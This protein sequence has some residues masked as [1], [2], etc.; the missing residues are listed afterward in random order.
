VSSELSPIQRIVKFCAENRGLVLFLTALVI[1]ASWYSAKTIHIDALPD[2]SDT[3]VVVYS[4]WDRSPDVLENQVTYPIVRSLLGAPK[5]KSIRAFTD[6]GY[7]FVY[8]IF[9]DEVDLYWARARVNE[10]MGKIT[11]SLPQGVKTEMGPDA[12][13]LGWVYQ[14][15]LVSRDGKTGPEKLRALNDFNLKYHLLSVPGV[16][17]IASMGG[18]QKQYQ[19]IVDPAK[20]QIAGLTLASVLD[21]VRG[22]NQQ[23]GGRL[24]EISGAEYMVRAHGYLQSIAD[25]EKISLGMDDTGNPIPLRAVASVNEASDLRRG[26]TDLDGRGDSVA[27]VVIMRQGENAYDVIERVKNKIKEI[28]RF[29]PEGVEVVPTY[30]RSELIKHSIT[31]LEEKLIEE[32]IIV[33]LVILLF[34]W[35]FPSAIIPILTIPIAVLASFI[36]LNL[37]GVSSNIMSLAGIA[38]SIGVLVDGAIV[39]V[40]NAYKKLEEWDSH[41]RVGDYHKVRLEALLEVGPSVFFS[42]L[43]VAVSFLPVFTLVDQEGRLFKPLAYSKN[44]AMAVAAV[45][46]ITV[47]PALRML[48]TRMEPFQFKSKFWSKTA[49]TLLVGKYLPEEKHPI[50]KRLIAWYGPVCHFTLRHP[51]AVIVGAVLMMAATVPLYF[52]LGGE[53]FPALYEETLLYMPT[54]A[55]GLSGAEAQK[56][57]TMTNKII[58]AQ[59]EVM[60]VFGKAGRAETSTDPAPLS[61]IET[62]IMLKPQAEW[63]QANRFYS[64]LPKFTWPLFSW[65]TPPHVTKDE[66]IEIYNRELKFPGLTNAFTMPIRNRVDM[67][68]TGMKTPLGLKIAGKTLGEIEEAAVKAERVVRDIPGVR[69][70]VA[71]RTASGYFLDVDIRRDRIA[72]YNLTIDDVQQFIR[73]AIGGEMLTETIEGRERYAVTIRYGK[74]WRDTPEKIRRIPVSLASGSSVPLGEIADVQTKTGAGMIRNENGFLTGYVYIDTQSS[75]L[76]GLSAKIDKAL[77]TL[78]PL[79]DGITIQLSGQYEN[80][81]RVRERLKIVIPITLFLILLLLYF[82]TRSYIKTLIVMLAVPFSL[83]GAIILLNLL[84]YH[85]SIAV[86]VGMIAL[87]GLDAET[88]VFMLMYLDLEFEKRKATLRSEQ[89]L[90]EVIY[91]GAVH[92]LRPKMMTVLAAFCGLL[93]VMFSRGTGSDIMKAI[94]APMVGGLFTS[95]LLE[96]IVY[97]PV[98]FLWKRRSINQNPIIEEVKKEGETDEEDKLTDGIGSGRADHGGRRKRPRR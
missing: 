88:G 44:L 16:A 67:L 85:I 27:G 58:A 41:G 71:E 25:I 96:L 11:G 14:Y 1:G 97:P 18:F 45:M 63:R 84:G 33:S 23:A 31:T 60:R 92:R 24:M 34:L 9:Q 51:R 87:M 66:L 78:K 93:P 17:E 55:P 19:V 13:G 91:L 98:Y 38:I 95:F 52:R 74:E 47:D 70:A 22:S 80:I 90:I 61:M 82:N 26:V 7:S 53:F 73:T 15:S 62:N 72:R 36:P 75:D 20:L 59:P 48:F 39:E 79:P 6:Y 77:D 8:V 32:I 37:F 65:I 83:I 46:A 10:Y 94:A 54:T 57:L 29:L 5:V 76:E 81:L 4:R 21:K 3:Q 50:S 28:G 64:K 68:S 43:V 35:H 56:L 2:L 89:E 12:T 40:E 30:D 49:T 86:W 42:L 69:S